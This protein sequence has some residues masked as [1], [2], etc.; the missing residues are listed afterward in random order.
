MCA[1]TTLGTEHLLWFALVQFK[2]IHS[3]SASNKA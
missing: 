3:S 2:I 1:D